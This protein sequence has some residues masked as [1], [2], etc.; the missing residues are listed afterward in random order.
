M[1]RCNKAKIDKTCSN[2]KHYYETIVEEKVVAKSIEY[3]HNEITN[4]NLKNNT[5][6]CTWEK[7]SIVNQMKKLTHV[8]QSTDMSEKRYKFELKELEKRLEILETT[9]VAVSIECYEK[10]TNKKRKDYYGKLSN[11]DK[12]KLWDEII[13]SIEFKYEYDFEIN[14]KKL[15]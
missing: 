12:R 1:Y 4:F 8:Y 11:A 6:I 13:E 5:D 10:L 2:K 3:L 15:L 9:N 7:H 14:F